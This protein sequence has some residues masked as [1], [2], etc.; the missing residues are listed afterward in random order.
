MYLTSKNES[1]PNLTVTAAIYVESQIETRDF[2]HTGR[3]KS[4][5]TKDPQK[6]EIKIA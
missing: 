1:K 3:P 2:L 5:A 4:L 6:L